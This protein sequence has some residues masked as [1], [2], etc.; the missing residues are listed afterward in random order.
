MTRF[1]ILIKEILFKEILSALDNQVAS[2]G[3][4]S[5]T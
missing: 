5:N 3:S 2:L 1:Q 4:K